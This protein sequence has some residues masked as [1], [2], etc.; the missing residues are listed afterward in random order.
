VF[1]HVPNRDRSLKA[2]TFASGRVV[3]DARRD[4]LT[5][6]V[7]AVRRSRNDSAAFVYRIDGESVGIAPIQLGGSDDARGIIEVTEG[8]AENDRVVTG[9][10]GTIGRGMRVQILDADRDAGRGRS[11]RGSRP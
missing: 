11:S 8:L 3:S 2:N 9:N 7:A 10:V 5:V 4:V 1:V 6:P